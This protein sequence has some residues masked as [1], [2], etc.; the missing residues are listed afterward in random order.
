MSM[1]G[2]LSA[3]LVF[4][5]LRQGETGSACV[6]SPVH[7]YLEHRKGKNRHERTKAV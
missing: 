4:C 2:G 5:T 6:I 3:W 1:L 7:S